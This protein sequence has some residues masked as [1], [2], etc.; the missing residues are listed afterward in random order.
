MGSW[1]RYVAALLVNVGF[2]L[3]VLFLKGFDRKIY[4]VDA[5]SVAGA[6]SILV[7]LLAWV[8]WAGAFDTIGYGFSTLLSDRKYKDLYE[9]SSRKQEKRGRQ[10]SVL[11]PFLLTGLGFLGISLLIAVL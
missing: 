7:G 5:L 8:A 2:T 10:S 11:L 9:Y 4:Y 1:K 3:L 6:V